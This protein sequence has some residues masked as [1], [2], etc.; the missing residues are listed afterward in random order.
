MMFENKKGVWLEVIAFSFM[1][2]VL[3]IGLR[4][5]G[6][7]RMAQYKVSVSEERVLQYGKELQKMTEGFVN[8]TVIR[9]VCPKCGYINT[10]NDPFC[11]RLCW[12]CA[13]NGEDIECVPNIEHLPGAKKD[14]KE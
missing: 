13:C 8:G 2:G 14:Q 5:L 12:P 9:W 11:D 3:A 7:E 4:Q 1:F 10:A 6:E